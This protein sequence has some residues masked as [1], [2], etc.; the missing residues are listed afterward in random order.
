MEKYSKEL[1]IFEDVA[2]NPNKEDLEF[3]YSLQEE[4]SKKD[5]FVGLALFGSMVSGYSIEESDIDLY[6]LYDDPKTLGSEIGAKLWKEI[7]NLTKNQRRKFNILGHN[8]NFEFLMYY[9]KGDINSAQLAT[10]L[11][12]MSRL[13]T[14]DKIETYRNKFVAELGKLPKEKKL[15]VLNN[16]IESLSQ[17]DAASLAKRKERMPNLSD[18]DHKNILNARKNMWEKRV[19]EIW[20]L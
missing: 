9:I 14:G 15:I 18:E 2:G 4:L 13:V 8:I 19:K 10:E 12:A 7:Q 3:L 6:M 11:G 1:Y 5:G 17:K 20:N 16:I